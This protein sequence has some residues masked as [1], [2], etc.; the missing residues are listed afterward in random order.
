MAEKGRLNNVIAI[1]DGR[2][3]A[4]SALIDALKTF[5]A[6]FCKGE[7]EAWRAEKT[8]TAFNPSLEWI[9]SAIPRLTDRCSAKPISRPSK[10]TARR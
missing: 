6:T 8:A 10:R 5:K 4:V 1:F 3:R 9:G 7:L 2:R